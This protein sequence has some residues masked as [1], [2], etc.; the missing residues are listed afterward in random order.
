VTT[1]PYPDPSILPSRL[2]TEEPRPLGQEPVGQGLQFCPSFLAQASA[3]GDQNIG[4]GEG[5]RGRGHRKQVRWTRPG[6]L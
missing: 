4:A 5:G 2:A 6:T 3:Q 1:A